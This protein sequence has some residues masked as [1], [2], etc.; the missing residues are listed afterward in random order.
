VASKVFTTAGFA[1]LKMALGLPEVDEALLTDDE[2]VVRQVQINRRYRRFV[3][4][5]V[6][7]MAAQLQAAE[8]VVAIKAFTAANRLEL[9]DAERRAAIAAPAPTPGGKLE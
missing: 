3:S 5:S 7:V 8:T 4:Q 6:D 9:D 1:A 2:W